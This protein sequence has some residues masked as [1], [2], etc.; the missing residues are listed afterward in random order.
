[1]ETLNIEE[2]R[3]VKGGCGSR[4]HCIIAFLDAGWD[5]DKSYDY[6]KDELGLPRYD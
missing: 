6:C 1:M 3:N 5:F 4:C 2:I